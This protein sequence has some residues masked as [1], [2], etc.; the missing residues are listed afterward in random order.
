M[1]NSA[2][3]ILIIFLTL[4][5]LNCKNEKKI[6]EFIEISS[7][8][9]NICKNGFYSMNINKNGEMKSYFTNYYRK[10][11]QDKI[12]STKQMDT[13]NNYINSMINFLQNDSIINIFEEDCADCGYSYKLII[14]NK[15]IK[16]KIFVIGYTN[17]E[18]ISSFSN[19]LNLYLFRLISNNI[20]K[21][22]NSNTDFDEDI[23]NS[24][25][26]DVR[27]YPPKRLPILNKNNQYKN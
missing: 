27:M 20:L 26:F 24:E 19:K 9:T 15:N 13:I 10:I 22:I 17:D 2:R 21:H 12:I 1:K 6:F 5:N 16:Y 4:F 23:K 11:Y 7:T 3:D 8:N 25:S 18:K 14:Q